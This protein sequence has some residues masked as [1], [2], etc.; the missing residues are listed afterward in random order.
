MQPQA[1]P[2]RES[3]FFDE[4]LARLA[5]ARVS[6]PRHHAELL[7]DDANVTNGTTLRGEST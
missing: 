6:Y 3:E 2:L 4:E 5:S 7:G 1:A